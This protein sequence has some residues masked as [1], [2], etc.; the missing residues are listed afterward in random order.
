MN[1]WSMLTIKKRS[2]RSKYKEE[3]ITEMI[4]NEDVDS[5]KK[6]LDNL[7]L[8][9]PNTAI[10]LNDKEIPYVYWSQ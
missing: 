4:F 9:V 2:F 5:I 8:T 1:R 7:E 6:L 3:C 10:R